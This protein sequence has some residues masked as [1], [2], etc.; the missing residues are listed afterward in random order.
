MRIDEIFG[1]STEWNGENNLMLSLVHWEIKWERECL[2]NKV[3][4]NINK[5]NN[6]K[7]NY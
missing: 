5:V 7:G 3:A 2:I 4:F 1:L 6:F